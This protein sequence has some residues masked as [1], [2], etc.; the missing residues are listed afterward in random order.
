MA[1]TCDCCT[2]VGIFSLVAEGIRLVVDHSASTESTQM[3]SSAGH[4]EREWRWRNG[5]TPHLCLRFSTNR[6]RDALRDRGIA[7]AAV[8]NLSSVKL[9]ASTGKSNYWIELQYTSRRGCGCRT[10][11]HRSWGCS[12]MIPA[13]GQQ[14]DFTSLKEIIWHI[15]VESFADFYK[16]IKKNMIPYPMRH[17]RTLSLTLRRRL[18]A[19]RAMKRTSMCSCMAKSFQVL[20]R[21]TPTLGTTTLLPWRAVS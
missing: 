3:E 9:I 8:N 21:N 1:C 15:D 7:A 2:R 5:R 18:L 10:Q 12:C 11:R 16:I 13:A 14:H 20:L 4:H 6:A 17:C 19:V